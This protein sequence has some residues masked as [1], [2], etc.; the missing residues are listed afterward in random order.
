MS[1]EANVS[2]TI[3]PADTRAWA[4]CMD[5]YRA[6]FPDWE[7]EPEARLAEEASRG[8]N[9]M[10]VAFDGET[11]K[12]LAILDIDKAD[13]TPYALLTILA[14]AE[15]ARRTGSGRKL[16]ED[17]VLWAMS[18]TPSVWL[19][20]EAEPRPARFYGQLGFRII[21]IAYRTPCF[22]DE[23][24]VPMQ[25]M[26]IPRD[27]EAAA[28]GQKALHAVIARIF[29]SGYGLPPDDPRLDAQLKAVTGDTPLL[30]SSPHVSKRNI[31]H[32]A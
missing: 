21:D 15:H 10:R 16:V 25:L 12:G 5:I 31:T 30:L 14:A 27:R 24:S 13:D 9:V 2:S 11:P 28:I 32:R 18:N 1:N 17:A 3:T 20:T 19:L 4:A 23:T 29:T 6:S 8:R 22:T 7:R 26:A